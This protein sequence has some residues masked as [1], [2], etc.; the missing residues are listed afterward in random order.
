VSVHKESGQRFEIPE[1]W[2]AQAYRLALDPTRA[3]GEVLRA[4]AGARNFAYNTML[5][6]VKANLEQR[7]AEKTYG[8]A[9]DELTRCLGWSMRSLRN[10]WN[11]LKHGVAVRG[12]GTPWWEENSKEAY[13]SGCRCLAN[14]LENWSQSRKGRGWAFLDLRP[15]AARPKSS[16]SPRGRC[17]W[18]PI[19]TT[20]C[21]PG[22]AVFARMNRPVGWPS[23][24][25]RYG[26]DAVGHR[27]FHWWALAV[28]VSGDR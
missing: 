3:Q 19:A 16:P 26:P 15:S 18:N 11:R 24:G 2:S 10:E 22:S 5:A 21:C 25:R 20:W 4:H 13:A 17:V 27:E 9:G 28:R 6:A 23:P 8:L 7:A 12:D 14:A 1:G